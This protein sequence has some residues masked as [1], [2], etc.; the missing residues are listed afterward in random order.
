MPALAFWWGSI[1]TAIAAI[2]AV[3]LALLNPLFSARLSEAASNVLS[4]STRGLATY[5]FST[6]PVVIYIENLITPREAARL[7]A[8]A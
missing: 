5:V 4:R 2:L 8:L 1:V 7:V 3:G 6:D